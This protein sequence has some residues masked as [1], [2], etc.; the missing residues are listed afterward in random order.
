MRPL[1]V[2]EASEISYNVASETKL[3]LTFTVEEI[4]L[5]TVQR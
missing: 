2:N 3:I 5:T 4:S 1:S